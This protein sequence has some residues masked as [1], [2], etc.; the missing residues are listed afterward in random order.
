MSNTSIIK[1]VKKK[2][3]ELFEKDPIIVEAPGRIN[4]I[5]EHTDYNDGYVLPA[6]IDKK[7]TFAIS[8]NDC[9]K[10]RVFALD[11]N[12]YYTTSTIQP[13]KSEYNWA[14]YLLGV[15]A[16]YQKENI[17]LPGI[18]CV[19]SSTIPIGAG[20]SSSAAIECGFAY[21]INHILDTNFTDFQLAIMSQKAE[22]E[23]AGVMC[24]IMDQYASIFGKENNVFRL[25]C[26]SYEH[27]Y[28]PFSM[29]EHVIVLCDTQVKHELAS[30]EYNLR[31]QQCEKGVAILNKVDSSIKALRD[32]DLTKLKK[33]EE[34]F[35]SITFK[36]CSYVVNENERVLEA[37]EAL[38]N[39]DYRLFGN[40]MY[41]SHKGL[42]DD[43]EVSC[44]ELDVLVDLTKDL[45]Y[46]IGSRMMGGGFGGCTINL[47]LRSKLNIFE[48]IITSMY[49]KKTGKKIIVFPVNISNGV[50]IE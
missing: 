28:F 35:D 30:S 17:D 10:F 2:F 13:S 14:N 26:R 1:A 39:E 40:L 18:D 22:H 44:D 49:N 16:Q 47:V 24:G 23:Y 45:D 46:V 8:S 41:N 50:N 37:C 12:S 5:G 29:E 19:F 42:A 25:D 20:L 6:A 3:A 43:Y 21:G 4:L 38:V 34:L 15:L 9:N 31:R 48:E 32:I 27:S 11:L 7:V 33:Y 36:R